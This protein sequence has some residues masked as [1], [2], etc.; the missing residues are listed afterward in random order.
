MN[1]G[2]TTAR[3]ARARSASPALCAGQAS[4]VRPSRVLSAC[5][6]RALSANLQ[7][8]RVFSTMLSMGGTDLDPDIAAL[9]ADVTMFAPPR[10]FAHQ[11]YQRFFESVFGACRP[12]RKHVINL[13]AGIHVTQQAFLVSCA[14]ILSTQRRNPGFQRLRPERDQ[15]RT[16]VHDAVE[17]VRLD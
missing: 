4:P 2:R 8:A 1:R 16:V 13:R 17:H 15:G 10:E 14:R 3:G 7:M 11:A 5:A 9:D 6:R 12:R